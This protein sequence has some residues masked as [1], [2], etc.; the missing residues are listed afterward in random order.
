M[1]FW[2]QEILGTPFLWYATRAAGLVCLVLLTASTVLGVLNSGRLTSKRW[3][4]FVIQGLHHNIALLAL[5]FLALHIVT[6]VLGTFTPIDLT[7]AFVPFAS[8]Y[9][10]LFLGL[11]AT[12]CDLLLVLIATSLV[13]Q[14]IGQRLWRTVHWAGYA[15]WP[16]AI[17]HSIGGGTDTGKGWDLAL[18]LLCL[19]CVG[20]SMLYRAIRLISPRTVP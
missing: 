10:R 5:A 13:R 17:A 19:A 15:C 9:H 1:R 14:R 3:P 8:P 2:H 18:T 11:G 20:A 6:T 4:R 7:D 12:A 16:V